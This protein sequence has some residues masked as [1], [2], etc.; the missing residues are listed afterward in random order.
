MGYLKQFWTDAVS[1]LSAARFNHQE[2]GIEKAEQVL[3]IPNITVDTGVVAGNCIS[4]DGT[5]WI[6]N[7]KGTHIYDGSDAVRFGPIPLSGLERKYDYFAQSDGSH[8][9]PVTNYPIGKAQST[10]ILFVDVKN[11]LLNP[12]EYAEDMIEFYA[13]SGISGKI[14]LKIEMPADADG[15][16]IRRKTTAWTTGDDKATGTQVAVITDDSAYKDANE[17]IKDNDGGANLTN[18]DTYYYKAFPYKGSIYNETLGSNETSARAGQLGNEWHGDSVSGNDIDDTA[19]E[20]SPNNA[21]GTGITTQSGKVGDCLVGGSGSY[22]ALN[23]LIDNTSGA[24]SFWVY[25]TDSGDKACFGDNNRG[26]LYAWIDGD[27]LKVGG[28]STGTPTNVTE[29]LS[30]GTWHHVVIN[31]DDPTVTLFVDNVNIGN[32][33]APSSLDFDIDHLGRCNLAYTTGDVVKNMNCMLDQV[34]RFVSNL[35]TEEIAVLYNFG[36]GC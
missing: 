8:G 23:S 20:A 16:E 22:A 31:I 14:R 26:S 4:D 2:D 35:T 11:A 24:I 27:T 21:T 9:L 5:K 15:V 19:D 18:G 6:K 30:S 25:Y 12:K 7:Q 36:G 33:T 3:I 28:G 13:T 29:E 17:W 1:V 10:S 32:I 34:K